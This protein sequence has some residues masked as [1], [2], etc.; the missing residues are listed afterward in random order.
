MALLHPLGLGGASLLHHFRGALAIDATEFAELTF[1]GLAR[2]APVG[3]RVQNAVHSRN[4]VLSLARRANKNAEHVN[5]FLADAKLAGPRAGEEASFKW[6][7]PFARWLCLGFNL[8]ELV[9]GLPRPC[10]PSLARPANDNDYSPANNV[11]PCS[12][13]SP[14]PVSPSRKQ[15][16]P[17]PTRA[18][19][20]PEEI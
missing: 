20:D 3:N 9:T 19:A 4:L 5:L 15:G 13:A 10:P 6:L 18:Y 17:R 1:V 8:Q 16:D 14:T 7:R 2:Q 12:A 11:T